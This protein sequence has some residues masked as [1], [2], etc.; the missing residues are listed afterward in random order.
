VTTLSSID[1]QTA[2][3]ILKSI[4]PDSKLPVGVEGDYAGNP[5]YCRNMQ[6]Y[7]VVLKEAC[8]NV[9]EKSLPRVCF[10][11]HLTRAQYSVCETEYTAYR[12]GGNLV[13]AFEWG[14]IT[15]EAFRKEFNETFK[16]TAGGFRKM[17][18]MGVENFSEDRRALQRYFKYLGVNNSGI[19]SLQSGFGEMSY[20]G[21]SMRHDICTKMLRNEWGFDG[22][23]MTDWF[24]T[25]KGQAINALAMK[26]GNDLIMPGGSYHKKELI[27]GVQAGICT[28]ED[29]RRCC[30]NVVKSI[31]N[32]ATQSEYIG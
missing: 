24:A 18:L 25:N 7:I 23:V 29:L 19:E 26:A 30:A 11:L 13:G 15:D 14:L 22:V 20:R 21:M 10:E 28:E 3:D 27:K 12:L 8:T 31:F 4:H 6:L 32:C 9:P 5:E 1:L 17:A 16:D 2:N